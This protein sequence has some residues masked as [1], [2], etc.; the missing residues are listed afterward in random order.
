MK[1]T[2]MFA[3]ATLVTAG[4]IMTSC[5]GSFTLSSRVLEWNQGLGSKWVNEVV[6]LAMNIVPVYPITMLADGVILNSVEFWTG[7]NPIA[8]G[9]TKKVIGSDGKEYAIIATPD[10]YQI[11][12]GNQSVE[13]KYDAKTSTWSSISNN[14][15]TNLVTIKTD[16]TA[17][18]YL[19]SG[20]T[21]NTTLD[22]KGLTALRTAT[23]AQ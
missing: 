12:Q 23:Q 11:T 13:L 8:A 19:P 9:T 4:S 3:I 7:S 16:G 6:F 10:G 15:A 21:F 5:I 17:N 1:K 22:S 18:V 14:E 2:K 20:E